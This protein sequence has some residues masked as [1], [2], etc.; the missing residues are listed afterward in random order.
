VNTVNLLRIES[1]EFFFIFLFVY[2]LRGDLKWRNDR[3]CLSKR[4]EEKSE[5]TCDIAVYYLLFHV[6]ITSYNIRK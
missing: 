3:K 4:K 2:S 5:L 6:D 1:T